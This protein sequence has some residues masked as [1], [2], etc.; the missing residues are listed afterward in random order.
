MIASVLSRRFVAREAELEQLHQWRRA[1]ASGQASVILI[2]GEAGIGKSRLLWEF[3]RGLT[4]GRA[5]L[6]ARAECLERAPRPLGPF[7]SII[8]AL[9][10]AAPWLPAAV[11]PRTRRVLRHVQ[12]SATGDAEQHQHELDKADLFEGIHALFAAVARKRAVV[13]TVEDL[14]WAD[15]ATLELFE[16]L[17]PRLGS[18]RLTIV[19]T[20]R[21]DVLP[22]ASP[23]GAAVARL[24]RERSVHTLSLQPLSRDAVRELLESALGQHDGVDDAALRDIEVR[25]EGNPLYAEELL[26]RWLDGGT[27]RHD[28]PRTLRALIAERVALLTSRERRVLMHAAVLGQRFD[29]HVLAQILGSRLNALLPALHRARELNLIVEDDTPRAAFRFRH[30]LTRQALYESQLALSRRPLHARIARVLETL[31]DAGAHLYEL[32]DHWWEAA[33]PE[34]ARLYNERAAA[35][36]LA[37]CAYADA[38]VYLERALSFSAEPVERARLMAQL[39]LTCRSNGNSADTV[40]W[41]L[42]AATAFAE[43]GRPADAVAPLLCGCA[44]LANANHLDHACTELE[45]FVVRYGDRLAPAA[46]GRLR[47]NLMLFQANRLDAARMP[48]LAS[49]G[50]DAGA[51]G[52]DAHLRYWTARIVEHA[53]F[54]E[55]RAW[56]AAVREARAL[57]DAEAGTALFDRASAYHF[58]GLTGLQLAQHDEV[59]GAFAGSHALAEAQALRPTMAYLEALRATE[60]FLTGRLT[61]AREAALFAADNAR[62]VT[63]RAVLGC[64]GPLIGLALADKALVERTLFAGA[65]DAVLAHGLEF[66]SDLACGSV[67]AAW[68]A[69]GRK[70]DARRLLE[71]AVASMTGVVHGQFIWPLAAQHVGAHWL[72]RL[73]DALSVTRANP[74]HH[75]AHAVAAHVEAIAA[76]RAGDAS[77]R[78]ARGAEAAERYC[79]LGW[80]LFEAQALELCEKRDEARAIYERCGSVADVRRM[81]LNDAPV[82]TVSIV[83]SSDA[84]SRRE[85]EIVDLVA[86]AFPNRAVADR[87]GIGEKTVESHLTSIYRKLGLRSRAQLVAHCARSRGA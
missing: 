2:A 66:Q 76:Q 84:L 15:A 49:L 42:N 26:K 40:R 70:A 9:A 60:A 38:C 64:A 13:L 86:D 58:I 65:A 27:H 71:A 1:A 43:A 62:F 36:A 32:A 14:H 44:E 18:I 78:T 39:G 87:L 11:T 34:R 52:D 8:D 33:Q 74:E 72:R 63:A 28:V 54:G 41:S 69:S 25:S 7:R 82:Q 45:R 51:F 56:R 77:Q 6:L 57:L 22:P 79:A 30:A 35:A 19:V 61:E 80:P 53:H 50:D 4:G 21:D 59:C 20:L 10:L 68:L 75:V 47:C 16:Y 29:P 31:P 3:T 12:A 5:P 67:A 17:A 83:R 37:I 48:S 55:L 81:A 73:V 23:L 46:R 85:R 24:E